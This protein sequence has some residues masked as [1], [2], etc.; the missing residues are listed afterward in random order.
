MELNELKNTWLTLDERLKKQEVLKEN[1][2]REM[3]HTKSDKALGRLIAYEI[4]GIIILLL[5]I[6][7]PIYGIILPVKLQAYEIFMYS[8]LVSILGLLCWVLFKLYILTR[9]NFSKPVS[10]N[11][12]HINKYN[13]LIKKEK[14]FMFLFIP[15]IMGGCIYLYMKLNASTML[16][17]LMTCIFMASLVFTLWS[18]KKIYDKNIDSI[19]KS[20]D[21]LKELEE[22]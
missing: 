8:V 6:P 19:Q 15:L 13:I 1:I 20:M 21:N 10:S 18:Y 3:L 22:E 9:I 2:M 11:I 16:W 4:F 14:Q 17:V 7:I 12:Y 5:V